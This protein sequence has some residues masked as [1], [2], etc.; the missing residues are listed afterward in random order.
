MSR[1][2]LKDVVKG[3]AAKSLAAVE[4]NPN[5]SNQH[6]LNG[7][8]ALRILFGQSSTDRRKFPG[9]AIY[10]SDD[11]DDS[12]ETVDLELTWYDARERTPDRTEWR[13]YFN[14][15]AGFDRARIGDT[16]FVVRTVEDHIL[17]VV[18]EQ[19]S[20]I[21]TQ[22]RWLFS[23]TYEESERYQLNLQD[24]FRDSDVGLVEVAL[25]E[26]LGIEVDDSDQNALEL[27]Q[28]RFP[29]GFPTTK[30]FSA[31][32]REYSRIE[33]A[34]G[35]SDSV[36][37]A[38][39]ETEERLFKAFERH[40]LVPLIQDLSDVD[41]FLS[42]SL[43]VQNRRKS[44]AGRALENHVSIVFDEMGLKYKSGAITENR[45]RPDFL[46]PGPKAYHDPAFPSHQ[47][48]M[49]GAK[50]TLKERWRQVLA[51]AR[52]IENKH[53]LTLDI[54]ISANQMAEMKSNDLQL[55]VPTPMQVGYV[56]EQKSELWSL[57]RFIEVVKHTQRIIT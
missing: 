40:L 1:I 36:L 13:L 35:L 24:E 14:D 33:L 46:F 49:L 31:F 37:V 47:L 19:G 29:S 39:M 8:V 50:S 43:S 2:Q 11:E 25:L 41:E 32:A 16:L 3:V 5:T 26:A 18:A 20:T 28:S 48:M 6:E 21:E 55:V 45:S 23:F 4:I 42:L 27:M 30:V 44:R 54:A 22:L 7:S 38:W 53:L 56:E 17:L 12:Y 15:R 9:S 34:D 57:D 52:R 51:E 10:L